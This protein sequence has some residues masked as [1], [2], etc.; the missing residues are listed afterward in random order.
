MSGDGVILPQK[1]L[2]AV[3]ERLR[4]GRD[5]TELLR[6][7]GG[8]PVRVLPVVLTLLHVERLYVLDPPLEPP[9]FFSLVRPQRGWDRLPRRVRSVRVQ[10]PLLEVDLKGDGDIFRF[11]ASDAVG[12]AA[13]FAL[14]YLLKTKYGIDFLED[15]VREQGELL[16]GMRELID[17]LHRIEVLY[18]V[19]ER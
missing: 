9:S 14:W 12:A 15:L 10:L 5:P 4:D 18:E 8:S 13:L 19:M 17:T 3:E 2:E 1:L 7:E 11:F 6:L 16:Q